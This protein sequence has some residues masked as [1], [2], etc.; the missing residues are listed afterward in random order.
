MKK[1]RPLRSVFK[2]VVPIQKTTLEVRARDLV[3]NDLEELESITVKEDAGPHTSGRPPSMN[4]MSL[5][6]IQPSIGPALK[7]KKYYPLKPS[8]KT[9]QIPVLSHLQTRQVWGQKQKG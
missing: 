7:T 2:R 5:K 6:A 9:I 8:K 1:Y 4:Q 3:R